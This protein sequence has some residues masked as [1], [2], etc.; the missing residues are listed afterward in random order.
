MSVEKCGWAILKSLFA[1]TNQVS[2][3]SHTHDNLKKFDI[4]SKHFRPLLVASSVIVQR[5][6]PKNMMNIYE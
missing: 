6:H 1:L 5:P 3:F 4:T 2:I